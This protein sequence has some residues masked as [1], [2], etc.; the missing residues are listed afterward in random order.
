MLGGLLSQRGWQRLGYL[1]AGL[2]MAVSFVVVLVMVR[3][4]RRV[5]VVQTR[6][7]RREGVKNAL[8]L[9]VKGVGQPGI[10]AIGAFIFL[11]NFNPFSTHVLYMHTVRHMGFS[12]QFAGNMVSLQA[13]ASMLA[14]ALYAGY[15][16]RLTVRQ[17]VWLSIVMGVLAT[18]SYWG[19][20]GQRSSAAISIVV[21]FVYMTGMI[22]QLDLAARVC[23]TETAGTT[24]ALLMSLS[25]LAVGLSAALGGHLYEWIADGTD[26][27]FAFRMLVGIGAL[28]T[29]GCVFLVPVLAKYGERRVERAGAQS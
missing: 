26:Y 6:S 14:A 2:A 10:L 13:F 8:R 3:E 1:I 9:L 4:P 21:G 24:F 17:L 19:L 25:N 5:A 27:T 23:D 29:C 22:V 7:E 20:A 15:S 18:T 16:K 28:F 11:W 12:E